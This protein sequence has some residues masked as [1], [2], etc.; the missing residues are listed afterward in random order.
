[1]QKRRRQVQQTTWKEQ[2]IFVLFFILTF[3][4]YIFINIM[5]NKQIHNLSTI[6]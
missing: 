6:Y 5:L 4:L 2:M 3:V 1:M